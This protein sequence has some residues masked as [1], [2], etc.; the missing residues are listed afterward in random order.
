MSA[1]YMNI[2]SRFNGS[3]SKW[4]LYVASQKT[5]SSGKCCH[6]LCASQ[7][8]CGLPY[9]YTTYLIDIQGKKPNLS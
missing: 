6:M 3:I 1:W 2:A 5:R 7:Q 8:E 4:V 9:V